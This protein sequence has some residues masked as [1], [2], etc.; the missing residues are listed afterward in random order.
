MLI[1]GNTGLRWLIR[2]ALTAA[3][4]LPDYVAAN[5]TNSIKLFILQIMYYLLLWYLKKLEL[6]SAQFNC[7]SAN[8]GTKAKL[9]S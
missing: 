4:L 5:G 7:I 6:T 2:L 3:L 9:K 1:N 8:Q